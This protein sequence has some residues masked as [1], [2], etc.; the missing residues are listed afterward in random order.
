MYL[1]IGRGTRYYVDISQIDIFEFEVDIPMC[2]CRLGPT[3]YRKKERIPEFIRTIS[4]AKARRQAKE[5]SIEFNS[6]DIHN[7]PLA[8]GVG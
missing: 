6:P 7:G 2:S 4:T 8:G 3:E 1:P 5:L